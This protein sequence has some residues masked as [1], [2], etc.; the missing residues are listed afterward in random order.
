[1]KAEM[2]ANGINLKLITTNTGFGG[3]RYWWSCPKCKKKCGILYKHPIS[4]DIA[5]RKC[6]KLKYISTS[7]KGMIENQFK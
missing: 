6:L 4:Q 7:K 2:N 3:E 1:M 5:C